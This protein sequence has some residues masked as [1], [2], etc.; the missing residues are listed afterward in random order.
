VGVLPALARWE[1]EPGTFYDGTPA[2][3]PYNSQLVEDVLMYQALDV[4]LGT[5]WIDRPGDRPAGV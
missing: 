1:Q 5:M 3:V 2:M 4:P